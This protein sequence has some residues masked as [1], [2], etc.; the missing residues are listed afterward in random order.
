[1]R[2]GRLLAE[3]SPQSLLDKHNCVK[4]EDVFF[5]LCELD[6]TDDEFG[7]VRAIDGAA[8]NSKVSQDDA[9]NI[10]SNMDD[11]TGNSLEMETCKERSTVALCNEINRDGG[12]NNAAV[13]PTSPAFNRSVEQLIEEGEADNSEGQTD[14]SR[15]QSE[16]DKSQKRSRTTTS[17]V[18]A[19]EENQRNGC[20][21]YFE[22]SCAFD[23]IGVWHR[24]NALLKKNFLCMWR[25][26]GYAQTC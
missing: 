8:R 25:N 15:K 21:E 9:E 22:N 1:M 19:T 10:A 4:L 18:A 16:S 13:S 12:N 7:S 3:D 6:T 26:I 5:K 14:K 2:N 11:P 24:M 17:A 23:P 20:V